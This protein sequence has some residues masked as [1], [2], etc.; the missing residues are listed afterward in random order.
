MC[1]LNLGVKGLTLSLPIATNFKFPLQPQSHEILPSHSK[2]NLAFYNLLRWEIIILPI[3]TTSLIYFPLKAAKAALVRQDSLWHGVD[4]SGASPQNS[5][6]VSHA[7]RKAGAIELGPN[8]PLPKRVR[9]NWVGISNATAL[10]IVWRDRTS[11]T[12]K[13]KCRT[14]TTVAVFAA[15]CTAIVLPRHLLWV[16]P[17]SN[18]VPAPNDPSRHCNVDLIRLHEL[19]AAEN[20]CYW[21]ERPRQNEDTLWRQHRVLPMLPVRGKTRQHCCEPR[22]HKKC[23]WRFSETF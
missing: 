5:L 12:A 7:P 17:R 14:T 6:S 16:S 3:L 1:F 4:T 18:P 11:Q 15:R 9:E 21:N 23:F 20:E 22:G 8:R 13:Q 19:R 2:E 10:G